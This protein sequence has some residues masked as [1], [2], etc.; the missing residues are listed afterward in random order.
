MLNN[1]SLVSVTGPVRKIARPVQR[2]RVARAAQPAESH[3]HP[4]AVAAALRL[5]GGDASR[6]RFQPDGSVLIANDAR[7]RR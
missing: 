5:A 4:L 3:V 7:A 1:V 6:L 2:P